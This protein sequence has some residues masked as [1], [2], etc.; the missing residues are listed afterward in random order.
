MICLFANK[1]NPKELL[2]HC[3]RL[4]KIE[5]IILMVMMP[6]NDEESDGLVD[7]QVHESKNYNI[8]KAWD[9]TINCKSFDQRF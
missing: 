3:K 8:I 5:R 4:S 9:L 1:N 7:P 6:W 2:K